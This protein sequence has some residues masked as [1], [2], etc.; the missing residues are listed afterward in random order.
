MIEA[1]QISDG[2][3]VGEDYYRWKKRLL[4]RSHGSGGRVCMLRWSKSGPIWDVGWGVIGYP[5]EFPTRALA[6]QAVW[7]NN[8]KHAYSC[9]APRGN[10][11]TCREV[12]PPLGEEWTQYR[13]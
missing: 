7:R 3:S 2:M 1:G 4:L 12:L 13:A 10:V 9:E 6:A 11:C 8:G 5:Q